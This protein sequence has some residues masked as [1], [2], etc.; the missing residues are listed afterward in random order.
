MSHHPSPSPPTS[1]RSPRITTIKK[2]C[3][4]SIGSHFSLFSWSRKDGRR[5]D[6]TT[7]EP[8]KMSIGNQIDHFAPSHTKQDWYVSNMGWRENAFLL[9]S[10]FFPSKWLVCF[11]F[12]VDLFH[13]CVTIQRTKQ[14]NPQVDQ[15]HDC[16]KIQAVQKSTQAFGKF[17][18]LLF[19]HLTL[20]S[21]F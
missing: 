4:T 1:T 13:W 6:P 5:A 12:S 17:F 9:K 14:Y 8:W 20:N 3:R 7:D 15:S 11:F 16:Q 10:I 2:D 21:T 18:V 19:F